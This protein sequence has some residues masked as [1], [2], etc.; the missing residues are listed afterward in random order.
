[1]GHPTTVESFMASPMT[2]DQPTAPAESTVC[3]ASS[4][5][6]FQLEVEFSGVHLEVLTHKDMVTTVDVRGEM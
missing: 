4:S 1:M 2:V 3:S 5:M 6:D